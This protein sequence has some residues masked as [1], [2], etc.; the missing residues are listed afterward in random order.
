[1][2]ILRLFIMDFNSLDLR[3]NFKLNVAKNI[4]GVLRRANL[5][6]QKRLILKE[7]N[8][9]IGDYTSIRYIYHF[10]P[11][12]VIEYFEK[13]ITT[14][15]PFNPPKKLHLASWK[16]LVKIA[17]YYKRIENEKNI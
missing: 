5:G 2:Q 6:Y 14:R 4:F 16:R 8:K 13:R 15:D 7:H 17:K 1:M 12:K 10:D 3:K 11:D 9:R